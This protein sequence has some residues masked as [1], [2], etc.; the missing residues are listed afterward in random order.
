MSLCQSGVESFLRHSVG[1]ANPLLEGLDQ[2]TDRD[3]TAGSTPL[4]NRTPPSQSRKIRPSNCGCSGNGTRRSWLFWGGSGPCRSIAHR[5]PFTGSR[6]RADVLFER[7][8]LAGTSTGRL[9]FYADHAAG[10]RPAGASRGA[11]AE[12]QVRSAHSAVVVE[13]VD[14]HV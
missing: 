9:S 6:V 14:T 3:H 4:S 5:I 1:G 10:G 2:R 7:N 11:C 12:S 13:L 8:S